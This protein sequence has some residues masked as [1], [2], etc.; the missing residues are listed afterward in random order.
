MKNMQSVLNNTP[1]MDE[2]NFNYEIMKHE[3]VV[4]QKNDKS[5]FHFVLGITSSA[6]SFKKFP[7]ET[8]SVS[9]VNANKELPFEIVPLPEYFD[10]ETGKCDGEYLHIYN[11]PEINNEPVIIEIKW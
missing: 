3:F 10:L 1:H 8:K 7:N 6:I 2:D 5:Y 4:N 11:I 9:L